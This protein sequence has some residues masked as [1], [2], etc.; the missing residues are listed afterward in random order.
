MGEGLSRL[1][2]GVASG[3]R[4]T[5]PEM[6]VLTSTRAVFLPPRAT[7]VKAEGRASLASALV[8][9]RPLGRSRHWSSMMRMWGRSVSKRR[10]EGPHSSLA[11]W[12]VAG[13]APSPWGLG[14]PWPLGH[15][16]DC[17]PTRSDLCLQESQPHMPVCRQR[18]DARP[19]S[20]FGLA[21]DSDAG[22]PH[23]HG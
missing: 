9:G 23:E 19:G 3:P 20:W 11:S 18:E 15:G 2:V 10:P 1:P 17:T 13:A 6:S 12:E 22:L 14:Q 7:V 16:A 8:H 4:R 5:H 21:R